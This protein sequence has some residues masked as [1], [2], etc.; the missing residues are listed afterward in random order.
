MDDEKYVYRNPHVLRGLTREGFSWAFTTF[1][2]ANWHPLTWLS[3]MLDAELFGPSPGWHH[4]MNVLYH[5]L[6]TN[7][8]FLVLWRMTGGLWQSAVVAALFGVHPLHVESVAWASER[9]DVL[10]T[11]FFLLALGA[12]L[13]YVRKPGVARYLPVA[14]LF[15]LGLLSKPM[16]VTFPFVLLLLDWWPLRRMELPAGSSGALER[17]RVLWPPV[18]EKIPLLAMSIASCVVTVVA[19]SRGHAINPLWRVSLVSRFFNAVVSYAAYLWKTVWPSSLAV[20]YPLEVRTGLGTRGWPI[21]GGLLLIGG[22]SFLAVRQARRRPY[23]LTGWLWY[24]G[25]LVP[26]IGL[27]QVGDQAMADRYTYIP[28]IGVFLAATWGAFEFAETRR[29]GRPALKVVVPAV[30]VSL[31]VAAWSQAG[32]WRDNV[33]LYSHA[34]AVTEKNWKVWNN[35]G[36]AYVELGRNEEGIASYREVLRIKPDQAGAW[37]NIGLVYHKLGMYKEGIA[38]YRDALK[39]QPDYADAWYNLGIGFEKLGRSQQA[40]EA[41][42]E[43][44]RLAPNNAD[45][46]NN[47]GGVYVKL[48]LNRQAAVFFQNALRAR[49]DHPF[50]A[51][52]LD[53]INR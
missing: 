33:A 37:N 53:L 48:G 42:R 46:W 38:S 23:L 14:A 27:V 44:I 2:A 6:N 8:L 24:L 5:L 34:L 18:R 1:H 12:Y 47:L 52:N 30:V 29:Y 10:S 32:Y 40:I 35:L 43:S 36:L 9:K 31:A 49:P 4:R 15:F 20:L 51:K 26:V 13:R 3:H 17:V 19:Q 22:I 16:L 11:L 50:A 39:I 45:A 41:Y 25:T 28:L 7:L 21:A